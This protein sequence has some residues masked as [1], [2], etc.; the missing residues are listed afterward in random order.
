M[1]FVIFEFLKALQHLGEKLVHS[2]DAFLFAI[3]AAV[4]DCLGISSTLCQ[5]IGHFEEHMV[6][7]VHDIGVQRSVHVLGCY[8]AMSIYQFDALLRV[9]ALHDHLQEMRILND[10][11]VVVHFENIIF[12]FCDKVLKTIFDRFGCTSTEPYM[13]Q[14]LL[15]I[16]SKFKNTRSG[17]NKKR[18]HK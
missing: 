7:P 2:D 12:L 15:L 17:Q 1:V 6:L 14:S 18:N 8:L 9:F 11:L 5:G 10:I 3:D 13:P 4:R 16:F